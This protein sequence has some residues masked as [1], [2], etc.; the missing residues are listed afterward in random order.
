MTQASRD[1]IPDTR[2]SPSRSGGLSLHD[3]AILAVLLAVAGW[4]RLANLGALGLQVDEG[5]QGL[6]V[7]GWLRTG[8]PVLPSGAVY[9]R[10]I[11]FMGLQVAAAGWFGLDE[12]AAP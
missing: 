3:L 6:A 9:Q 11:P 1:P 5:V 4:L 8:L 7:E 12:F 10:S 2:D